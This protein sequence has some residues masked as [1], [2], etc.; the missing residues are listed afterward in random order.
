[1]SEQN[2]E[3]EFKRIVYENDWFMK[4]LR[5]VQELNLPNWFIGAGVIS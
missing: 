5:D 1:M 4:L 3:H 2:Y